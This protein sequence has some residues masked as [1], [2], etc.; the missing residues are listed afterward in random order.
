MGRIAPSCADR[1][2]QIEVRCLDGKCLYDQSLKVLSVFSYREKCCE[3]AYIKMSYE[4]LEM[5]AL[6]V[7]NKVR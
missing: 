7:Y 6:G 2:L 4:C 3:C 5:S 1:W